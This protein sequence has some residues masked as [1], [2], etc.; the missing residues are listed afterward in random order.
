MIGVMKWL[1][2]AHSGISRRLCYAPRREWHAP[3]AAATDGSGGN[4]T[5]RQAPQGG[6]EKPHSP[7][8][9][10]LRSREI[11]TGSG[12]PPNPAKPRRA[13]PEQFRRQSQYV[14]YKQRKHESGSIN[15][16]IY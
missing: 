16:G 2:K 10:G 9:A 5:P 3:S 1:Q 12:T 14:Q 7:I 4:P 6:A 11:R 8:L 13:K 15:N